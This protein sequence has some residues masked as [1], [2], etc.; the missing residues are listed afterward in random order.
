MAWTCFFERKRTFRVRSIDD[1]QT[2]R[3]VRAGIHGGEGLHQPGPAVRNL[4]CGV[5]IRARR[6]DNRV[7]TLASANK[8]REESRL[9]THECVRHVTLEPGQSQVTW[10]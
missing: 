3:S 7:E 1:L 8:S 2:G 6:L 9:G 4:R 10:L 5:R